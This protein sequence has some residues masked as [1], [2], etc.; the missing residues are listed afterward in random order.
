M[1]LL[2]PWLLVAGCWK[3]ESTSF[4]TEHIP[5]TPE[6]G[7]PE[8]WVVD[9][10]EMDLRCPDGEPATFYLVYPQ[11]KAAPPDQQRE[12]LPLA[13]LFHSG[14][15]DFI[16]LPEPDAPTV[17]DSYQEVLGETKRITSQWAINRV[18][19]TLGMYNND[20][21]VEYHA[22]ALPAALATKGIAMM[23]PANCWGDWWHNRESS[24]ENNFQADFYF[25]NGRTAA[26]FAYLHATTA[27]P[28]GN[29]LDLPFGID[30][31]R[32]YLIGLGE[33]S[34]AVSE[35]VAL[36]EDLGGTLGGFLYRPTAI[37]ADS[38]VDDLRPYYDGDA[39]A[40]E[41]IRSGLN[42]IFPGGRDTVMR[43]TYA[44]AQLGN[45]PT[46]TAFLYS[47]NDSRIPAG[48]NDLALAHLAQKSSPDLW[49]Y[50]SIEPLHVLTNADVDLSK[51][52]A[53][54]LIDGVE[55]VPAG[56]RNPVP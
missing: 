27:F 13:I 8:G 10:L 31:A 45:V 35:L 51:A 54:Y 19:A 6:V 52:V 22:G 7:A 21:S 29:P 34:R 37:V 12:R 14:A 38:P 46:R 24:E 23:L 2:V 56:L 18:F 48:A 4:D 30:P 40:Y 44:F 1:R 43:G 32:I 15:F 5:F 26:E 16:S 20:D 28:P 41:A 42:R 9:E 39:A 55:A 49:H 11:D 33:G 25:R 3:L 50:Q 47:A 53:D 17:G 36:R